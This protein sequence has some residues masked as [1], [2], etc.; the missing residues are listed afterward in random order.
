MPKIMFKNICVIG[1]KNNEKALAIK[2]SIVKKYNFLDATENHKNL[3]NCDLII[4]VGGDGLM[5]HL[6]HEFE[7]NPVP[8]YGINAGTVGF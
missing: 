6:L 3:I 8:I 7:E 1:A 2:N 4:A 5:L